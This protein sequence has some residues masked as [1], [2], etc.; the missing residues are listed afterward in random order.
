MEGTDVAA[1]R[2]LR[3]HVEKERAWR[4]FLV[5]LAA[6]ILGNVA[7]VLWNVGVYYLRDDKAWWFY[8]PLLFWGIGVIV[9][10]LMAVALFDNW[11]DRDERIIGERLS[12]PAR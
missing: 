6:Y 4:G 10:F 2:N 8:L 12:K 1:Y 11:W 5:H 9:H 3:K 7:L